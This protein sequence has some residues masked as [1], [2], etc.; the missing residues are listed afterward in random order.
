M[1]CKASLTYTIS[2]VILSTIT[3]CLGKLK[4]CTEKSCLCYFDDDSIIY[5]FQNSPYLYIIESSNIQQL[6]T[7]VTV[8]VYLFRIEVYAIIY[9]SILL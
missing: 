4:K 6:S 3:I 9:T 2:L 5:H 8:S 7:Q 1:G